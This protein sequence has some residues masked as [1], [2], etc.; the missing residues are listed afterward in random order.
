MIVA[1]HQ[2][3]GITFRTELNVRLPRLEGEA[4]ERFRVD[5]TK[6]EVSLC[7]HKV[8]RER[9]TSSPV[10]G[11]RN[12]LL[13][14]A[15]VQAKLQTCLDQPEQMQI[16]LDRSLATFRNFSR[17]ELD[18]FYTEELWGF[19]PVRQVNN[20]DRRIAADFGKM[21]STFLPCFSAVMI[22]SAAVVH[23]REAALFLAPSNGGK[24]TMIE[25]ADGR[26][27]L[28]DDQVVLR[29]DGDA[30]SAH[31]TPLGRIT[32]GPLQARVGGLFLLEKTD[33]FELNHLDPVEVM[34]HLWAELPQYAFLLPRDLRRQVFH[35]LYDVCHQVP[36]Y[37]MGFPKDYVNWDAIEAAMAS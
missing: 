9:P 14:S 12:D 25:L 17:R 36:T 13:H 1:T 28:C 5:D 32:D 16:G 30:F 3:A 27:V 7:I 24:T 37:R 18:V 21:F 29:K 11:E 4:F 23:N 6:P 31:G 8:S 20:A 15:L 22:H 10:A 26:P 19:D 35:M 2:I 34:Q 33:H